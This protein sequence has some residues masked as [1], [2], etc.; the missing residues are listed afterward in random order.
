MRG[1][2]PHE[3]YQRQ[4]GFVTLHGDSLV[5]TKNH[6]LATMKTFRSISLI[7]ACLLA[8]ACQANTPATATTDSQSAREPAPA[9]HPQQV[10]SLHVTSHVSATPELTVGDHTKEISYYAFRTFVT[11]N[12]WTPIADTR[13]M[14]NV[15]GADY[16]AQ[17]AS[18][19]DGMCRTC[20]AIPE[21]SSCGAG[22][23]CLMRFHNAAKHQDLDVGTTGDVTD[24]TGDGKESSLLVTGWTV[25][26]AP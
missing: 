24:W 10:D 14:A 1:P 11:A 18:H 16:K 19:L 17:C 9:Q 21:L 7:V 6:D 3:N 13:C 4:V 23:V 15:V 12:G 26:G 20:Q 2:T 25:T 5:P 8:C 22:G